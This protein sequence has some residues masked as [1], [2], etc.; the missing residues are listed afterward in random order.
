MECWCRESELLARTGRLSLQTAR[1][2]LRYSQATEYAGFDAI[3]PGSTKIPGSPKNGEENC[4][5]QESRISQSTVVSLLELRDIKSW[6]ASAG[7]FP[8]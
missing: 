6:I 3:G 2:L 5:I 4:A 8:L 7:D 1:E